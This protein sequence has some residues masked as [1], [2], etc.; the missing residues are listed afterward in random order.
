MVVLT[1]FHSTSSFSITWSSWKPLD[2]EQSLF[3]FRFSESNA[4]ARERRS[5]ETRE[6]RAARGHLRVSRFARRTTEK[7]ETTR[8]LENRM[9]KN[10]RS[11]NWN[12]RFRKLAYVHTKTRNAI[13]FS[14]NTYPIQLC[15]SPPQRSGCMA[16]LRFVIAP[17]SP[18][19]LICE[20]KP[21]PV[22]FSCRRKSYPV[23]CEHSIKHQHNILHHTVLS[24]SDIVISA[25]SGLT[26]AQLLTAKMF[27]IIIVILKSVLCAFPCA[28]D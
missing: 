2:C 25:R 10:S 14:M 9:K 22:R 16:Q 23:E 13:R 12:R 18:S 27:F 6:T 4:R 7:I 11:R 20:Q 8:S 28:V 19:V 26:M 5:C 21:Y 1:G 17:K 15:D 24:V 3:F